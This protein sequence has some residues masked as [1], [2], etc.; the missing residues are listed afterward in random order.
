MVDGCKIIMNEQQKSVGLIERKRGLTPTLDRRVGFLGFVDSVLSKIYA[1]IDAASR[2]EFAHGP[3]I[4]ALH[5]LR[6]DCQRSSRTFLVVHPAWTSYIRI[7]SLLT[8]KYY[9][10]ITTTM[11]CNAMHTS[12]AGSLASAIPCAINH[13]HSGSQIT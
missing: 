4:N 12:F 13:K 2:A 8:H 9:E 1:Y 10:L 7:I 3:V 11:Q 6:V 5:E